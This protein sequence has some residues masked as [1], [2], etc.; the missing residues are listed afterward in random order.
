MGIYYQVQKINKILWRPFANCSLNTLNEDSTAFDEN[1]KMKH[2]SYTVLKTHPWAQEVKPH[3]LVPNAIPRCLPKSRLQL[4]RWV[5]AQHSP[6]SFPLFTQIPFPSPV[7]IWCEIL[8]RHSRHQDS[9]VNCAW[10]HEG[11][12]VYPKVGDDKTFQQ[13]AW[14]WTCHFSPCIS[15]STAANEAKGKT[16]FSGVVENEMMA[17]CKAPTHS[18]A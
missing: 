10:A 12:L 18:R 16:P 2:F 14:S 4:S 8:M 13:S 3:L 9:G 11:S 17:V 7:Q 5:P 1:A 15:L 6:T